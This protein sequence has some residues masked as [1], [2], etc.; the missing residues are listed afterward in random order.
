MRLNSEEL[1]ELNVLPLNSRTQRFLDDVINGLSCS[2]KKLD[3]KYFYDE[4]GDTLFQK[5]MDCPEYYVTRCESEIFQNHAR[6]IA[7]ALKDELEEFDLI[8]LGAGDA[9]KTAHLLSELQ[10]TTRDLCYYPIDISGS[11]I[12]YLEQELPR[13]IPGL[14]VNGLHGEYL[15][16]L[17][18]AARPSQRKKAVLFLGSNIGNMEPQEALK[19]LE[20]VRLCLNQ[21]DKMLIGVDLKKN[22]TTVLAAYDDSPGYTKAFNLNLLKRINREL[23]ADFAL[24]Q[25]EH[26]PTYDPASGA[27]KSFLVSQREQVVTI[28]SDVFAFKK[29]EVIYMELSQKYDLHELRALAK[30]AGF[31]VTSEFTDSQEW[32]VDAIWECV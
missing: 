25:F 17:K 19:F 20:K 13:K 6:E 28:S 8:E 10:Q 21:G 3:S 22:P 11:I 23:G 30:A 12:R 7:V 18:K 16:M 5:I 4:T 31:E 24:D 27:C 32:F 1:P 9:T 2:P 26:Y 29:G 14:A 15:A